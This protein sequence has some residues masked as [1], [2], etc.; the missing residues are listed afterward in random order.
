VSDE[1]SQAISSLYWQP[2]YSCALSNCFSLQDPSSEQPLIFIKWK[3]TNKDCYLAPP[4]IRTLVLQHIRDDKGWGEGQLKKRVGDKE[5]AVADG[6]E[7]GNGEYV[8]IARE[9]EGRYY[10]LLAL[11]FETGVEPLLSF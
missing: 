1:R 3:G 8:F 2:S 7:V 10:H 9:G 5:I 11:L 4:R 6:D